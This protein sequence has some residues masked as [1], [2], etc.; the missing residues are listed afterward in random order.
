MSPVTVATGPRGGGGSHRTALDGLRALAIVGVMFVH[1]GVPGLRSGW[2]GVDLFFV[3]SGFLITTLLAMES[4]ASGS[5][6]YGPFMVRRALR[7]MPAYFLYALFITILVWG[8]PGSV[9][10]ENGGW[11]STGF[12]AALWTY[13]INFVPKGGVW[14]GQEL[15][16]HLWSLAVEQQYYLVWPLVILALHARPA[17]LR[18][19]AV[20]LAL[21]A[22]ASF[23]CSPPG[24]YKYD[25]LYTRGFSLVVASALALWVFHRPGVLANRVFNRAVDVAGAALLL[26][27][28]VFPYKPGW[29]EER[30][31]DAFVPLLVPVFGWWIARLWSLP[32]DGWIRRTLQSRSL[33]Y[34][35]KISYGVYLYHEAVRVG[36]WYLMK[37]VMSDWT[38]ALGF[39]VRMAV[40]IALSFALAA[41]S[42][43]YFEKKFLRLA[44]RFRPARAASECAAKVKPEA[45]AGA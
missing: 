13:A 34:I 22:T 6:A 23:V 37:P 39:L 25:M 1:A 45:A 4:S 5:I 3:L 19:A 30:T 41:L 35:G 38:P 15:T 16:V 31:C 44:D 20:A 24:L 14:N 43:E 11:T 26:T 7:L 33:V 28:A 27:L 8:W 29:S 18:W 36:V 12:T 42:Y 9:R 2:I 21:A 32:S 40:Y 10:T 17:L